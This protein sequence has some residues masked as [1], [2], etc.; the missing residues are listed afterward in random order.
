MLFSCSAESLFITMEIS[1]HLD[2]CPLA[3][4]AHKYALE[5]AL[6]AELVEEWTAAE[7]RLNNWSQQRLQVS[8]P[9]QSCRAPLP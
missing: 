7:D 1:E 5:R 2:I 4:Q 6:K 9:G 3:A 8:L